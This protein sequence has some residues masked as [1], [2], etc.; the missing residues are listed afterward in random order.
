MILTENKIP[1]SWID[2]LL[3]GGVAPDR[4]LS[5]GH[6]ELNCNVSIIGLASCVFSNGPGDR[7]SIPGRVISKT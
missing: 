4:V 6:I 7:G 3:P 2:P 5:M 1:T